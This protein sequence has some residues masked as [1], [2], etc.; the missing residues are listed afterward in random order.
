[1]SLFKVR[2]VYSIVFFVSM[3]QLEAAK[4]VT[5]VVE[6]VAAAVE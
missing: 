2:G 3:N 5:E 1:M 6:A 4:T